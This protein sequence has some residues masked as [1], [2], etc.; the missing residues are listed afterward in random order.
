M[1]TDVLSPAHRKVAYAVFAV[2]GVALGAVQVGFLSAEAGQ[3]TWLTV[4]LAVYGFLAGAFGFTTAR[5]NVDPD[6]RKPYTQPH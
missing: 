1:L 3:P 2:L 5:A 4:A 6:P